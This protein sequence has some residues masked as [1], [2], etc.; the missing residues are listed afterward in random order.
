LIVERIFVWGTDKAH[1]GEY[2]NT[3]A[4]LASVLPG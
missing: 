1:F 2:L 3:Y 4:S